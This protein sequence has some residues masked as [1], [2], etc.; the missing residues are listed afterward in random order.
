MPP[1]LPKRRRVDAPPLHGGAYS[2][3]VQIVAADDTDRAQNGTKHHAAAIFHFKS[4][5]WV[6]S[7]STPR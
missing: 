1:M 5:V 4:M 3:W 7:G 6:W 2:F